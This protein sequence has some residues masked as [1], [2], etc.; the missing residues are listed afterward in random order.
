LEKELT[1]RLVPDTI[2]KI[3]MADTTSAIRS[4]QTGQSFA[5]THWT[6]VLTAQ[7][8]DSPQVAAALERL[9]Q[10]YWGAIYAYLRRSGRAPADAADLTQ[11]FFARFL[12]KRF[13]DDVDRQKGRFRSFLLKALNHFL[14]DEW[15]AAH[16]LKR[17]GAHVQLSIDTADWE[18]R[19]GHELKS[20]ANPEHLFERRWAMLVFDRA[21]NRMRVEF[22]ESG[23]EEE[24]ERLKEFLTQPSRDGD[25]A[26]AAAEL[27][28]EE[29]AVAVR[30]HRLRRRF[31]QLVRAEVAQTVATPGEVA[32]ELRHLLAV[33]SE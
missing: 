4:P 14:A 29:G 17:G 10:T 24:F 16:A 26:G 19:F 32:E 12:E 15:R 5:T 9:C 21:L 22:V 28:L 27:E 7:K 25:Y 31:G 30:V 1:I 23:R 8:L 13:L 18:S 6:V 11:A 33:L 20:E 3:I 2:W